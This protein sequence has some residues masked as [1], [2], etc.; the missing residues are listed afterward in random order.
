MLHGS[1][2][3]PPFKPARKTTGRGQLPGGLLSARRIIVAAALLQAS[4]AV[5]FLLRSGQGFRP[6]LCHI[7]YLA[8]AQ[9][10]CLALLDHGL[11]V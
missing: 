8:L 6:L 2:R 1:N 5:E 9:Q 4:A 11:V 7:G 10:H 3:P